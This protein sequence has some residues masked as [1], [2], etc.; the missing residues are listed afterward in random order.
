MRQDDL[1]LRKLVQR[2]SADEFGCENRVCERVVE[3]GVGWPSAKQ[4]RIQIV[5]EDGVSQFFNT[6]QE[7]HKLGLEQI[8]AV[9]NGIRQVNGSQSRLSGN[10]VATGRLA[11]ALD[12]RAS[13]TAAPAAPPAQRW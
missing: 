8:I 13:H 12:G 7:R 6:R 1:E 5:K 4:I 10:A 11:F 3:T 9:V 2:S